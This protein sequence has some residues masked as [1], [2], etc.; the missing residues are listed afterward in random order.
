[1]FPS[2]FHANS[3]ILTGT[4][5]K[6]AKG[7]R[8]GVISGVGTDVPGGEDRSWPG[9]RQPIG[10]AFR[11]ADPGREHV[12]GQGPLSAKPSRAGA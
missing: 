4:Y 9:A 7:F 3:Y 8:R 2:T 12:L 11:G 1:M 6:A 10:E 5:K